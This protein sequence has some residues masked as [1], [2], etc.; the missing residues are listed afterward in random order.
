MD[1]NDL[2]VDLLVRERLAA[3]RADAARARLTARVAS[4]RRGVRALVAQALVGLARR[5]D[6]AAVGPA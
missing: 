2:F 5:I 1:G 4:P 6:A 3:A